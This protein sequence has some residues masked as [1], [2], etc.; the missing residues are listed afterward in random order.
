[1]QEP[2]LAERRP[3]LPLWVPWLLGAVAAGLVP[4]TLWLTFSL[5]SRHT[6]EHYDLAWVGFD[7]ALAAAFAVTAAAAIR[8]AGWLEASAAITGTLLLCDAWFDVVTATGSTEQLEAV[9]EAC[10]A[11]LPLAAICA[12]I[13]CDAKRFRA[14]TIVR[15]AKSYRRLRGRPESPGL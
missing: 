2:D 12:W 10:L 14:T 11:E 5:P 1:V 8:G 3:A 6:T 4:W 9:L 15:Y 13:V 7:V